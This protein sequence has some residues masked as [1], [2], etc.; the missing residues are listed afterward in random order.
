MG[1]AESQSDPQMNGRDQA[2]KENFH[3]VLELLCQKLLSASGVS[4]GGTGKL[5]P[6]SAWVA[7]VS[8]V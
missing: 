7:W 4:M 6:K 1:N 3:P 5:H 8:W 2:L